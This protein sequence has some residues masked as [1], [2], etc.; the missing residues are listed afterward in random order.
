MLFVVI[1]IAVIAGLIGAAVASS[2]GKSVI[3]WGIGCFFFPIALIFLIFSSNERVA[4]EKIEAEAK[5]AEE[6]E[7]KTCPK[8]AE[9]IK[10]EALVCKHCGNEFSE[11]EVTALKEAL[12]LKR[13]K[14]TSTDVVY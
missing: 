8:C 3:G 13:E 4:S 7:S 14:I 9:T 1:F 11:E 2:K 5:R 12:R 10:L 6:E